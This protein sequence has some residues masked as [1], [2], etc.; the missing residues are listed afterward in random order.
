MNIKRL[1]E[2]IEKKEMNVEIAKSAWEDAEEH[3]LQRRR[4]VSRLAGYLTKNSHIE[5]EKRS[6]ELDQK[7]IDLALIPKTKNEKVYTV[8]RYPRNEHK[9]SCRLAWTVLP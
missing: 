4:E 1:T 6:A 2:Q 5:V 8:F 3:L 9:L 7:E